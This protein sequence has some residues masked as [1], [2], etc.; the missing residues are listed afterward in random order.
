M[1]E[2]KNSV[3]FANFATLV[4]RAAYYLGLLRTN[5]DDDDSSSILAP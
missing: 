1:E 3:I 2:K 4:K 5:D